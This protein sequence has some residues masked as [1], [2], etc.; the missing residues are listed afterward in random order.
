MP[1]L[2]SKAQAAL[3]KDRLG[4]LVPKHRAIKVEYAATDMDARI[5]VA[6]DQA[7]KL[8]NVRDSRETFQKHIRAVRA[9]PK[10]ND[11]RTTEQARKRLADV[12]GGFSALQLAENVLADIRFKGLDVDEFISDLKMGMALGDVTR[13]NPTVGMFEGAKADTITTAFL[14]LVAWLQLRS[15]SLQQA[16][17]RP[18]DGALALDLKTL[19]IES[20]YGP[21]EEFLFMSKSSQNGE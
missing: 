7:Q 9:L 14:L 13:P 16:L 6:P 20:T 3:R 5:E 2:P 19:V 4:K 10:T 15:Q 11:P 1:P 12:T 18:Y 21:Q 17:T 8:K